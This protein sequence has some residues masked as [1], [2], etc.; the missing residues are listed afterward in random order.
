MRPIQP[1]DLVR[2]RKQRGRAAIVKGAYSDIEGGV[3]LD[4][5]LSGFK[6]WNVCDLQLVRRKSRDKS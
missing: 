4:R 5:P 6:S 1:G 2:L 3:F